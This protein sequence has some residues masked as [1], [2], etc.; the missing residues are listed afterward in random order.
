MDIRNQ[1]R[2]F[3]LALEKNWVTQ[4]VYFRLYMTLTEMIVT[5]SWIFSKVP[6]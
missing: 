1:A 2:Q 5:D 4:D 3:D 6:T